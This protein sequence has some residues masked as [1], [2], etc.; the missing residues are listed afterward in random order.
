MEHYTKVLKNY[1]D[2]STRA[3]RTEYWMFTLINFLIMV[4]ISIIVGTMGKFISGI[5]SV[6]Y[7]LLV[8]IPGLAVSV[9]RLHD[10]NRS[11]WWLL[12]G[13]VPFIGVIVILLFMISDSTPG[14]NTYGPNPKEGNAVPPAP[15]TPPNP[16]APTTV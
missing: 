11:G 5:V 3:T 4:G 12:I 8:I 13:F 15:T 7:G 1:S 10:T 6:I 9:R 14:A 16:P 2:F